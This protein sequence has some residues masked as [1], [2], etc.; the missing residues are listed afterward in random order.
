MLERA[1]FGGTLRY[2]RCVDQVKQLKKTPDTH[3]HM[4]YMNTVKAST[5]DFSLNLLQMG[6]L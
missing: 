2:T 4:P 3:T 1:A 6:L 5:E